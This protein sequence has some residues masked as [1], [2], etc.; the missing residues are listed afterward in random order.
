MSKVLESLKKHVKVE[1]D[2]SGFALE[3]TDALVIPVVDGLLAK[4][5]NLIPGKFDDMLIAQYKP[6]LYKQAK[7]EIEKYLNKIEDK[8]EDA[9]EP[10]DEVQA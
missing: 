2:L 10:K 1:V 6:E 4:L 5:A 7:E 8:I 3:Q 9:L